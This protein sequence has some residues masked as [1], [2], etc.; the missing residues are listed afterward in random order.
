MSLLST[1][2]DVGVSAVSNHLSKG[3]WADQNTKLKNRANALLTID[4]FSPRSVHKF[5]YEFSQPV[6]KQNNQPIGYP[7]GGKL[8]ITAEAI[9][10]TDFIYWMANKTL[11]KSGMITVYAFHDRTKMYREIEFSDARVVSYKE[12]WCDPAKVKVDDAAHIEYIEIVWSTLR[13][14]G[15]VY[16]NNWEWDS[17]ILGLGF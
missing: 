14:G 9:A 17:D 8:K 15:V 11:R 6:D 10:N 1:A 16:D 2:S 4:G 3:G 7:L 12:T 13:V 5:E